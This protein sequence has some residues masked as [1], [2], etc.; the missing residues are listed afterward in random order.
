MVS[1]QRIRGGIVLLAVLVGL[2]GGPARAA[3]DRE[4]LLELLQIGTTALLEPADA[5]AVL[6]ANPNDAQLWLGASLFLPEQEARE[7]IEQATLIDPRLTTVALAARLLRMGWAEPF[8]EIPEEWAGQDPDN[9][10]PLYAA[11]RLITKEGNK[12][13][14]NKAIESILQKSRFDDYSAT[15]YRAA[16][17]VIDESS[18]SFKE[19]RRLHLLGDMWFPGLVGCRDVARSL[20]E[21]AAEHLR[22]SE[23]DKAISTAKRIEKVR[24]HVLMQPVRSVITTLVEVAV[25]RIEMETLR[26][27]YEAAG[28]MDEAAL[29]T[30][31]LENGKAYLE[32]IRVLSY[33]YPTLLPQLSLTTALYD[34]ELRRCIELLPSDE[35]TAHVH[36]LR[37]IAFG[38]EVLDIARGYTDTVAS[39]GEIAALEGLPAEGSPA[40]QKL[41]DIAA[42]YNATAQE[43]GQAIERVKPA[44]VKHEDSCKTNLKQL[45]LAL[46][47]YSTDHAEEFPPDISFLPVQGYLPDPGIL[48]CFARPDE[49]R[50][51]IY[52]PGLRANS[53][54]SWIVVYDKP[55][56]HPDGY[57]ALHVDGHV[58]WYTTEAFIKK[59]A[60]QGATLQKE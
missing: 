14:I 11:F 26:T 19:L 31:S 27:A 7:A 53:N 30:Q 18:A 55:G 59:L 28:R 21:T 8:Q 35:I 23:F 17:R 43:L 40:Y 60:E 56:N 47:L 58:A 41:L 12:E 10:Y 57:N 3:T 29:A 2:A 20:S 32:H 49:P 1:G 5:R 22:N 9:A 37:N 16:F 13:E 33:N 52:V 15:L 24:A 36:V 25:R 4:W 34:P 54:P 42:I 6:Q 45:G 50:G 46:H 51:Y 48:V 39:K 38:P 44:A